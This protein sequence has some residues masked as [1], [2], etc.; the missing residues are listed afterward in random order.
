MPAKDLYHDIVVQALKAEGWHITNDPLYIAFGG[1]SLYVD[2]GAEYETL[3]A[4]KNGE[5]LAVEIKSF[6]SNSP[7]D[8]LEEALGSYLLYRCVLEETDRTRLVYLAVPEEAWEGIFSERLGQLI[9]KRLD[10]KLIV[11]DIAQRSI[12][13]WIN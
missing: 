5:R 7:V 13:Q 4:E 2:L 8:D 6:I 9:L 12:V 1:R 3:A 11:F 10:L